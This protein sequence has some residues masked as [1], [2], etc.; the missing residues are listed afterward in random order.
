LEPP[1]E[2]GREGVGESLGRSQARPT[3]SR[4]R[5]PVPSCGRSI[6]ADRRCPHGRRWPTSRRST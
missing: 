4:L 6:A 3:L 5:P 1:D 2:R